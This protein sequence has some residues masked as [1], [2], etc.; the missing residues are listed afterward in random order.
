MDLATLEQR[1]DELWQPLARA[2]SK[3][4]RQCANDTQHHVCNW[5]VPQE[6][7]NRLCEACRLNQVIPNL[8]VTGD[9]ERWHK[10]EV[11]KRRVCTH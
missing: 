5:M 6:D 4:Y 1:K 11:A 8:N 7:P 3:A 9:L 2:H 10:L